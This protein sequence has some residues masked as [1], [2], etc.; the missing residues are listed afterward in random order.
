MIEN[1]E[2]YPKLRSVIAFVV[3]VPLFIRLANARGKKSKI[4]GNSKE[5]LLVRHAKL[6]LKGQKWNGSYRLQC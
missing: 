2:L 1:V 3:I 6:G 5:A 4:L